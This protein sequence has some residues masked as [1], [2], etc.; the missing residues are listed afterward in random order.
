[1]WKT[2]S[3]SGSRRSKRRRKKETRVTSLPNKSAKTLK[4]IRNGRTKILI[5][6]A[7]ILVGVIVLE[8]TSGF[9]I[10][11][12]VGVLIVGL[13][14]YAYGKHRESKEEEERESAGWR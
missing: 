4:H 5:S 9:F 2:D 14:E 7:V 8:Y 1:L 3:F 6:I 12:G 13:V 11:V 10:W